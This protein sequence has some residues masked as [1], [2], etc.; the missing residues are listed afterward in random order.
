MRDPA[1]ATRSAGMAA[2][3][4]MYVLRGNGESH[5]AWSDRMRKVAHE[6]L[7]LQPTKLQLTVTEAPEDAI[8][9][10]E[11]AVHE[12]Y[13]AIVAAG[14]D[15]DLENLAGSRSETVSVVEQ[16]GPERHDRIARS[17][18]RLGEEHHLGTRGERR[19]HL[20]VPVA[21]T[22]EGVDHPVAARGA[23]PE[24]VEQA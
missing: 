1:R 20:V 5:E 4:W 18:G 17:A 14:G 11:S 9:L 23:V 7:E 21:R 12:G 10:A 3:K 19:L 13:E 2:K 8:A 22:H 16:R 24:G 15:V 6:L